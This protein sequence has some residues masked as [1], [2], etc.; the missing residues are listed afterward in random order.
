MNNDFLIIHGVIQQWFALATASLMKIIGKSPRI[1]LWV[2]KIFYPQRATNYFIFY[3][4]LLSLKH[5]ENYEHF[6]ISIILPLSFF[7]YQLI[8]VL[9]CHTNKYGDIISSF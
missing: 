6:Q 7:M 3:I 1:T 9:W 2:I 4:L 5:M 8:A